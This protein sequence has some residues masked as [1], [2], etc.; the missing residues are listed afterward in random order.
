[1][2]FCSAGGTLDLSNKT[3]DSTDE[4][5]KPWFS[6][7]HRKTRDDAIIFGHWAA[8]EGKANTDNI[9]ALDTGCVWGACLTLMNLDNKTLH[10]TAC[11]GETG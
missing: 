10:T 11:N 7:P 5:F 4:N 8:L 3:N 9:Y 6:H 2:R 1:M